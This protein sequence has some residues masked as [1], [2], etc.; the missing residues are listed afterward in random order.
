HGG[1]DRFREFPITPLTLRQGLS[2]VRV[3]SVL[4]APDGGV[5]LRTVDGVNHWKAGRVTVYREFPD[6]SPAPAAPP[7]PLRADRV[8][9]LGLSGGP[10]FQD[11]RGRVWTST[12][13][14]VGYFDRG[15]FH[16]APGVPGGRVLAITGDRN[17]N[18]W[19]AYGTRGL[20]HLAGDRL[21][22]RIP[23]ASVG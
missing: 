12:A 22:D 23:W 20:I 3:L 11:E 7:S 19:L 17:G 9:T 5:W 1:L 18:L 13:R 6:L 4:A 16:V 21:V 2:S 15:R 14:S 8:D 10:L